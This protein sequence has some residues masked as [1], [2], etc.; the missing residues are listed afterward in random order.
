MNGDRASDER[1]LKMIQLRCQGIGPTV[2]AERFGTTSQFVSVATNRVKRA[3]IAESGEDAA[4]SYW[5]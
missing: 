4:G 3:D 2:I 1:V 5:P